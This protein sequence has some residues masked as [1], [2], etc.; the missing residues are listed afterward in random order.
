[1]KLLFL[2]FDKYLLSIDIFQVSGGP[3]DTEVKDMST[4]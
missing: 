2:S 1:M 3:G 4:P